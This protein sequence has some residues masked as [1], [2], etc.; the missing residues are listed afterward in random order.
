MS[1]L[2][3][4]LSLRLVIQ[5]A[6]FVF[7][8]RKE[9]YSS[10]LKQRVDAECAQLERISR[11]NA[12]LF[13]ALSRVKRPLQITTEVAMS[14]G[15]PSNKFVNASSCRLPFLLLLASSER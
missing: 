11:W 13:K 8:I 2:R 9:L 3:D 5:M 7:S 15:A 1:V 6:M 14:S 4:P 12:A 10:G